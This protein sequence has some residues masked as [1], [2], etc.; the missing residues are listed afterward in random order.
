MR[1]LPLRTASVKRVCTVLAQVGRQGGAL[2]DMDFGAQPSRFKEQ[3]RPHLEREPSKEGHSSDL[4]SHLCNECDLVVVRAQMLWLQDN[5]DD[6]PLNMMRI[7]TSGDTHAQ[8][9]SLD[10]QK[11]R[12]LQAARQILCLN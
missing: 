5:L 9:T 3:S 12:A 1:L 11:I 4:Q 6:S 7:T 8:T 10:V 2:A